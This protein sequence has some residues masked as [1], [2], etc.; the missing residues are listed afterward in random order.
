MEVIADGLPLWQGAQLAIDTVARGRHGQT[1]GSKQQRSGTAS[2][3]AGERGT[4]PE[5]LGEAGRAR[6]VVFAAEVGG[7]RSQEA[8]IFLRDLA[9]ARAQ[10]APLILQ[11]RVQAARFACSLARTFAVSLLE[12]WPVPGASEEVL[13]MNDVLRDARFQ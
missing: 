12:L 2:S 9:K 11:G 3:P 8:S 6:L 1:W 5:L 13:P 10:V 4:Y 7:R